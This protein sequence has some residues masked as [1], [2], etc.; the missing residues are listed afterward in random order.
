[1]PANVHDTLTLLATAWLY[2]L[3][4]SMVYIDAAYFDRRFLNAFPAI[5]YT[6]R[7]R[8][9]RQLAVPAFIR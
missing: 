1:M 3:A 7:R 2:R 6:P 8:D 5:D 9:R 4:V